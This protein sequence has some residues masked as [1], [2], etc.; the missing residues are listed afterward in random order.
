MNRYAWLADGTVLYPMQVASPLCGNFVGL[1][2]L[3]E[4]AKTNTYD[5]WCYKD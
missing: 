2:G 4:V 1:G 5:A 3:G